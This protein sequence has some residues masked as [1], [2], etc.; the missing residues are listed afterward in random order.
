MTTPTPELARPP[1]P[2]LQRSAHPPTGSGFGSTAPGGGFALTIARRE[3]AKLSFEHE[4]DRRDVEL[5]IAL[6]AEKRASLVGRGPIPDDVHVALELFGLRALS[7][8]DHHAA[9]PFAGVAHSYVL[10]RRLV[11]GVADQ[12]LLALSGAATVTTD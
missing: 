4:H 9:T 1:K 10:Q 2:G 5:G 12:D 7:R 8:V 3:V 11:D 6:V